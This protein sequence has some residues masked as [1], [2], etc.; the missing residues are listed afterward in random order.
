MNNSNCE[1]TKSGF[2]KAVPMLSGLFAILPVLCSVII[3]HNV[4]A[5]DFTYPSLIFDDSFVH[6]INVIV[7]EDDWEY[8]TTYSTD[9]KY[10]ECDA[11]I[12]GELIEKIGIRPM[13]NS[14]LDSIKKSGSDKY[15]FKFKFD[16]YDEDKT[17]HGLD[18]L[19]LNNLGSDPTC[20]K[21]YLA[22][23][24]MNEMDVPSP[25]CSYALLQINGVDHNLCLATECIDKSFA[26]RNFGSDH[27]KLYKPDVFSIE[28]IKPSSFLRPEMNEVLENEHTFR[29]D[30]LGS[31]INVAFV[32]AKEDV[33]ISAMKY[34][35]DEMDK[36]D[37][38]FDKAVFKCKRSDK[39]RLLEAIRKLDR[40]QK[41][42]SG[43][44]TSADEALY[45]E[46][47]I[48]Y[49]VVHNFVNNYDGYTG[50]FVH[51]FYLYENDSKLAMIPWDYNLAFGAFSLESATRSFFDGTGYEIE[52]ETNSEL[53]SDESFVNYPIDTP[54][55]SVDFKDRPMF[56]AWIDDDVYRQEYHDCFSDFLS[57]YF[58]S[59]KYIGECAR[60]RELIR[61]YIE[62]GMTFY[63]VEDFDIAGDNLDKYSLLRSMSI[64]GQLD[65]T[66]PTTLEGQEENP[67]S[68]IDIG[69]L[70]LSKTID[71]NGLAFGFTSENMKNILDAIAGEYPHTTEGISEKL[72]VFSEN[73]LS[74]PGLAFRLIKAVPMLRDAVLEGIDFIVLLI[75]L[76]VA[77]I[78]LVRISRKQ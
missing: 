32:D 60:V 78:V 70:D 44:E 28:T 26:E 50:Y 48:P 8:T 51:N 7:D 38:I 3:S 69:D 52:L 20:M 17:Y 31:I 22:Y 9:E 73:P 33:N 15:S 16:C 57:A 71:F 10:I 66:I 56:A 39:E 76:T 36:Y 18:K 72:S 65:G 37:V 41:S 23:H 24:M 59:G 5:G 55:Y 40:I 2:T 49:F 6:T 77:A 54:T 58:D 64:K 30:I 1:I 61:P 46:Y 13:G 11:I 62:N 43:K 47:V 74:D 45:T 29:K 75:V 4:Y 67:D 34:A 12:D 14:S 35:G 21:N 27:G 19:A 63:T 68:L 25:L 42:N 53:S